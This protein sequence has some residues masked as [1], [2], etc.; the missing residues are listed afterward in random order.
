[1]TPLTNAAKANAREWMD[2]RAAAS[3]PDAHSS[4]YLAFDVCFPTDTT[5][6]ISSHFSAILNQKDSYS[7]FDFTPRNPLIAHAE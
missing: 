4:M 5:A 7:P 2:P 6:M 1:M 3:V